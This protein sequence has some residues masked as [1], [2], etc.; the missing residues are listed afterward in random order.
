MLLSK[1]I[2]RCGLNLSIVWV[3]IRYSP[4]LGLEVECASCEKHVSK[5]NVAIKPVTLFGGRATDPPKLRRVL[6][7][8]VIQAVWCAGSYERPWCDSGKRPFEQHSRH[9]PPLASHATIT[10]TAILMTFQSSCH[11]R[12]GRGAT[13][14]R[15]PWDDHRAQCHHHF[16]YHPPS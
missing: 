6:L 3:A 4:C 5:Y 11:H 2:L 14:Q 8:W 9:C 16:A 12:I 7:M 10:T 15:R 13:E 1:W